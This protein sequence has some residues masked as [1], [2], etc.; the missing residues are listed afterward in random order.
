M[1]GANKLDEATHGSP[2]G[3]VRV[4]RL[5]RSVRAACSACPFRVGSAFVYDADALEALDQ[6][7]IPSCHKIA[8]LDAIFHNDTPN[9]AEVCMGHENWCDGVDGF[10]R[11]NARLS[12]RYSGPLE[13]PV[14][15]HW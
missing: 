2:P 6:G 14:R 3:I 4:D 13:P 11:P 12:G 15:L 7:A 8:G 9:A 5:V 10:D 1:T